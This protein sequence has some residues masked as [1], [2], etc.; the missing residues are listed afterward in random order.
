A[1]AATRSVYVAPGGIY[2]SAG[3][4][5]STQRRRRC[6]R[7]HDSSPRTLASRVF[8]IGRGAALCE[9]QWL[10]DVSRDARGWHDHPLPAAAAKLVVLG[11]DPRH[12]ALLRWLARSFPR[13]HR[14]RLRLWSY[15]VHGEW[16]A[17]CGGRPGAARAR[18]DS[19]NL[20]VLWRRWLGVGGGLD[21]CFFFPM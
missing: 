13:R 7:S 6:S 16:R 1:S 3:A 18:S 11:R 5:Q 8:G 21:A 15:P 17:R 9:P 12:V 2:I 19:C 4:G 10:V 14:L 20:A